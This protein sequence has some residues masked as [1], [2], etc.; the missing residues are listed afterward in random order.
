[1]EYF[2]TYLAEKWYLW[3]ITFSKSHIPK[4]HT[5]HWVVSLRQPM[6]HY[7]LIPMFRIPIHS[8]HPTL[9]HGCIFTSKYFLHLFCIEFRMKGDQ[10]IVSSLVYVI[11]NALMAEHHRRILEDK[12][13]NFFSTHGIIVLR[14]KIRTLESANSYSCISSFYISKLQFFQILC[15]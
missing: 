12:Y 13:R 3:D 15:K 9:S 8:L 1:M 4:R 10:N 6:D 2:R 7:I 11:W 14:R 5:F